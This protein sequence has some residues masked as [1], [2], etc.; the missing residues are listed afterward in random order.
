[1]STTDQALTSLRSLDAADP[2]ASAATTRARADLERI[3]ASDPGADAPA[4]R[5]RPGGGRGRLVLAGVALAAVATVT[6]GV[7]ALPSVLG[8]DAAF[9]SWTSTPGAMSPAQQREA[10][11]ACRDVQQGAGGEYDDA[12]AAAVPAVAERRG[13]WTTVVLAGED[14]FSALCVTDSSRRLFDDWFGSVGHSA[15]SAA[16]GP[17]ALLVTDLGTGSMRAGDLSLAAGL[18]GSDVAAV[19]FDSATQGRVEATVSHGR[20]ALWLPGDELEAAPA[21]GVDLAVTYRDG[22]TARVRV[23][24]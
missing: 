15:T 19:A 8:G 13:A 3:V 12:L 2:G 22:S 18:V 6:V 5:T 16:P 4:R 20:F 7:V 11:E 21:E 24:L 23:S 9:A 17:R 10:A 1:M 14:G